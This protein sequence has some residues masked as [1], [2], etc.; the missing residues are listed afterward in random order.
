[1][2]EYA[3]VEAGAVARIVDIDPAMHASW[4]A[5]GNPK[6]DAYRRV[7]TDQVPPHDIETQAVEPYFVVASDR[8]TR[9]WLLRPL[10]TDELRKN[11]TALEFL[12]RFTDAELASIE[13]A[14]EAD[15]V[16]QSFYRSAL[17][18]QEV[19]S[20]DPRT[21]AGMNYLVSIGIL[22]LGRV[23]AILGNG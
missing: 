21:I 23:Q 17:A 15:A 2:A 18:A 11:W 3:I 13:T 6:A 22:S 1:M 10:T 20:D 8:V 12:S 16:V 9:A 7:V 5:T 19:V 14:R 4:V